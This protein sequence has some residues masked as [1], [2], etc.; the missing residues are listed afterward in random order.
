MIRNQNE[1]GLDCFECFCLGIVAGLCLAYILME[2]IAPQHNPP[3]I[4]QK[5][6]KSP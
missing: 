5:V 4:V 2:E 1:E 3:E 6:E